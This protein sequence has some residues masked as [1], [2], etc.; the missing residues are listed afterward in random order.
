MSGTSVSSGRVFSIVQGD[1]E[2]TVFD[3]GGGAPGAGM[4][5]GLSVMTDCVGDVEVDTAVSVPLEQ[6]AV[7][8]RN[9]T[10]QTRIRYFILHS[11]YRKNGGLLFPNNVMRS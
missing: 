4:V 6:P 8:N 11:P 2:T 5:S 9:K 3:G 10:V 7:S 1:E